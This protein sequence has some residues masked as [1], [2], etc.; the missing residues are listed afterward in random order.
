MGVRVEINGYVLAFF[1]FFFLIRLCSLIVT[2]NRL[3][4]HM[5]IIMKYMGLIMVSDRS[6]A[7]QDAVMISLLRC[8]LVFQ[9]T[10]S[11]AIINP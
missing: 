3:Y 10:E 7:Q 8:S 9:E 11:F 1:S 6:N 4:V 2:P 5:Y